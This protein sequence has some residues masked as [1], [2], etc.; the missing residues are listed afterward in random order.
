MK[1]F[2]TI[3]SLLVLCSA[4]TFAG[5]MGP[6]D[7]TWSQ[8]NLPKG[9]VIIELGGYWSSQ[10]NPQTIHIN[11]LIGDEFSVTDGNGK[12]G[13]VGAGYFLEG[14][15]FKNQYTS[16]INMAYGLNFFYLAKTG[17]SGD[18]TQEQ[19]F[20]NLAYSYNVTHYPL[21]AMV[22]ASMPSPHHYIPFGVTVDAGIGPNFIQTSHFSEVSLDGGVTVPDDIFTGHNTTTFTVTT[23]LALRFDQLLKNTPIECGYRFFYLGQGDFKKQNDQ[24][25]TTL[26]TGN[27]FGNALM[28]SISF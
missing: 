17:V 11:D 15:H 5:E 18:V 27:T 2:K 26:N 21:Y 20:T 12:N 9:H 7:S 13:A 23:G 6:M 3:T 19:L 28:C 10:G 14:Q 22:K 25:L 1:Q 8:Y 16:E 4:S 24:V